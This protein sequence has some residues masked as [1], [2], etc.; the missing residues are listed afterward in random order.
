MIKFVKFA[1]GPEEFTKI[2]LVLQMHGVD[3]INKAKKLLLV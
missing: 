3:G 2:M 1:N